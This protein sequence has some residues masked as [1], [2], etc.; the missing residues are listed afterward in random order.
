MDI[1]HALHRPRIT[2]SVSDGLEINLTFG[3]LAIVTYLRD[4]TAEELGIEACTTCQIVRQAHQTFGH[5]K[6]YR[7]ELIGYTVGVAPSLIDPQPVGKEGN[8]RKKIG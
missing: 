5:D 7:V 2:P 1:T 3:P 4:I 6:R 8:R